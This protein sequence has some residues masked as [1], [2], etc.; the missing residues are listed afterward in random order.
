M[1]GVQAGAA[2]PRTVMGV[3]AALALARRKNRSSA[4]R[5]NDSYRIDVMQTRIR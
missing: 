1:Q 4:L 2:R 3:P 5:P